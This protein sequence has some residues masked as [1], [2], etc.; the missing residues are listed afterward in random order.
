M[1]AYLAAKQAEGQ[2]EPL[3]PIMMTAKGWQ[4]KYLLD[5]FSTWNRNTARVRGKVAPGIPAWCFYLS[6][7][8]FGEFK[9]AP[10]GS[11]DQQSIITPI[12][13]Y[14]PKEITPALMENLF[15]GE[16]VADA[17]ATYL[18][19]LQ[20]WLHAYENKGNGNGHASNGNGNHAPAPTGTG[21]TRVPEFPPDPLYENSYQEDEIPF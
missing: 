6:V 11:G 12:G 1:I 5:A 19:E 7:G 20:E 16:D 18:E 10:V 4:G 15:V 2:Y 13:P 21:T 17:M 8:T 3:G 14:I 9:K